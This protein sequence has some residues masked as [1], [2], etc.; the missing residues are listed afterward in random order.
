MTY[1]VPCYNTVIS[2]CS[3]FQRSARRAPC[4]DAVTGVATKTPT[5]VTDVNV[6]TASAAPTV[7]RWRLLSKV[8][9]GTLY[10]YHTTLSI[11]YLIPLEILKPDD[12]IDSYTTIQ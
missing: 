8:S 2:Q 4:P 11:E 6:P 3:P 7:R 5:T 12:H 9:G 1:F 10:I